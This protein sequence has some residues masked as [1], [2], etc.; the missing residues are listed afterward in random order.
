MTGTSGI[1]KSRT[2]VRKRAS[3][4]SSQVLPTSHV[5]TNEK[6]AVPAINVIPA[7]QQCPSPRSQLPTSRTE[8]ISIANVMPEHPL[9]EISTS[10]R[11]LDKCPCN[12]SMK[13]WKIDCS[14]C[15]QFWHVECLK[16][17]G[18]T[19]KAY[20]KMVHYLCP[21][22]FV[23]PVPTIQSDVDVCHICRNTLTL[24]QSNS[25]QEVFLAANKMESLETFCK[26]VNSIDFESISDQLSA[27]QDLDVHLKHFLLDT[28]SLKDHQER[29][30]K[31]D[32][33]IVSVSEQN[34]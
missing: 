25:R 12:Q 32:E 7:S 11:P 23:P 6:Q 27:V 4:Q 5:S 34:S 3:S 21:F 31:V 16:M 19:E 9:P 26:T 14:K 8:S 17:D 1:V 24:Q 2:S 22:C 10:H 30:A 33:S 28:D 20:N 18:L 13:S 29:V 15:H